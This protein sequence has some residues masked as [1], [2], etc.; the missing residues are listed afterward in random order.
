MLSC[1]EDLETSKRRTFTEQSLVY[2]DQSAKRANQDVVV[3]LDRQAIHF[4][5]EVYLSNT[6]T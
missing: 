5:S 6:I 1:C 3:Q 2:K 4:L